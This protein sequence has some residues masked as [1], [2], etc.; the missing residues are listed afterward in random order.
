MNHRDVSVDWPTSTTAVVLWQRGHANGAAR[1]SLGMVIGFG[2]SLTT[3]RRRSRVCYCETLGQ[4]N[5]TWAGVPVLG[6]R[7]T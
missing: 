6:Y 3:D 1:G 7:K 5:R 2:Y 4:T